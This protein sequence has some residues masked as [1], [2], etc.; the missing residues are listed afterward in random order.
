MNL[1][2][3][4]V[5]LAAQ[6]PVP[7]L[8]AQ[9]CAGKLVMLGDR[10]IE[11]LVGLEKRREYRPA[12]QHHAAQFH[13]AKQLRIGQNHLGILCPRRRFDP[14]PMKAPPRLVAA[15]IGNDYA[16]CAR[17]P[18]LPHHFGHELG[19]RVG[20]LLRR[21]VPRDIGLDHHNVLTAN[22][23]P[24]TAKILQSLLRQRARFSALYNGE[25]WPL[26]VARHAMVPARLL[27]L[28]RYRAKTSLAEP[29]AGACRAR[30]DSANPQQLQHGFPPRQRQAALVRRA[31]V[32][33]GHRHPPAQTST[34]LIRRGIVD[35]QAHA[36]HQQP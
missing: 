36:P 24:H 10:Q 29:H 33:S 25:V 4:P 16:L 14:R 8:H 7:V 11:N 6:N 19:I 12:L 1:L 3:Q 23:A 15:H 9:R 21:A 5:S 31:F 18:A 13:L 30:R 27:C 35:A 17:L 28:R 34:T 2:V 22:K 32:V 20:R 26:L